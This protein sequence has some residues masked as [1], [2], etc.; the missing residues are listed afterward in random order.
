MAKPTTIVISKHE[1]NEKFVY[2]TT[3]REQISVV[4][5]NGINDGGT[6][7]DPESGE[8][9]DFLGITTDD[10]ECRDY[11]KGEDYTD[12]EDFVTFE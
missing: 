11:C 12:W 8:D 5:I 6:P 2:A 1:P 3:D 4:D 7:I 9:L 10:V